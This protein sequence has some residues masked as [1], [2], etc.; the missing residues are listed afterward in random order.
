MADVRAVELPSHA[1]LATYAAMEGCFTDCYV[2]DVPTDVGLAR[3]VEAFYT[4]P[5]FKLERIILKLAVS[6]PST[7]DEARRLASG[8]LESF[9]AW[10]VEARTQD[11]LLMADR[12]ERTRSW[13]M[14]ASMPD[15]GGARTRL[16]FGSAV[17]PVKNQD[18]GAL[19]MSSGFKALLGFHKIYARALLSSSTRGLG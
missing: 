2:A 6:R 13:F 7:D 12:Q 19:E 15:S 14:V 1:L 16:Y 4:T 17:L 18:T 11:Q 9:S 10:N 3:F 8:Q 5:L